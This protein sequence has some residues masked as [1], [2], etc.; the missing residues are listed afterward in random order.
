M[1]EPKV[2]LREP[3]KP[4]IQEYVAIA[5]LDRITKAIFIELARWWIIAIVANES[6]QAGRSDREVLAGRQ[7]THLRQVHI[8]NGIRCFAATLVGVTASG[9]AALVITRFRSVEHTSSGEILHSRLLSGGRSEAVS[10]RRRLGAFGKLILSIFICAG[11]VGCSNSYRTRGPNYQIDPNAF[12]TTYVSPTIVDTVTVATDSNTGNGATTWGRHQTR[13]THHADGTLRLLYLTGSRYTN[14][15][16]WRLMK[17]VPGSTSWT[18]EASAQTY[19]DAFLVRDPATD[20]AHVVAWPGL[21]GSATPVIYSSNSGYV[22]VDLPG[23]TGLN[24]GGTYHGVGIG[25]DGTLTLESYQ[26][27]NVGGVQDTNTDFLFQAGKFNGTIWSFG[28]VYNHF[29][30]YRKAYFYLLPGAFGNLG[31][32]TSVGLGDVNSA[33]AGLPN[34]ASSGGASSGSYLWDGIYQTSFAHNN[35]K[36]TAAETAIQPVLTTISTSTTSAY[37]VAIND[38]LATTQ[39]QLVVSTFVSDPLNNCSTHYRVTDPSG[40][41]IYQNIPSIWAGNVRLTEDAKGRLWMIDTLGGSM[42]SPN[43]YVYPIN[44]DFSVATGSGTNLPIAH[45]GAFIASP[46]GGNMLS[47]SFEGY[48]VSG[49]NVVYYKVRLPN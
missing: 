1:E 34:L 31:G 11:V 14:S 43:T 30:G 39:G 27:K 41:I 6:L 24:I 13:F 10:L 32:F 26:D 42:R 29:M 16:I 48:Y 5:R 15:N 17:R 25:P 45:D 37:F 4:N 18:L 40:N 22:P 33:A 44:T 35:A 12:K 23:W 36:P 46:R 2:I 49:T 20:T 8:T 19:D 38:V 28:A 47:D 7:P 21:S 3:L 9:A